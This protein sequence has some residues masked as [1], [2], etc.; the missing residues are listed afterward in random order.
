M[1]DSGRKNTTILVVDDEECLLNLIR[2][3]LVQEGYTVLTAESAE[4]ALQIMQSHTGA[5]DILLTDM[6]MPNMN[7]GALA[8]AFKTFFPTS[9][10]IYM[11]A[12]SPEDAT[13]RLPGKAVLFKP[14]SPDLLCEMVNKSLAGFFQRKLDV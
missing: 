7:G 14:F 9:E 11:T 13:L 3:I 4:E 6:R 1:L 10:V 12:Y 2:I 5:I 8:G